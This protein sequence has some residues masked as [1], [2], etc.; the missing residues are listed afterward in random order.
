M[1]NKF[2]S[3][4]RFFYYERDEDTLSIEQFED[5]LNSLINASERLDYVLDK[6]K[7]KKNRMFT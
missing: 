7:G 3:R 5:G 2:S 1:T 6:F 4:D